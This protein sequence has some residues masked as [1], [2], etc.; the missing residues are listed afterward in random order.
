MARRFVK[1][2]N[3]VPLWVP[4]EKRQLAF[5]VAQTI[6]EALGMEAVITNI[7][8]PESGEEGAGLYLSSGAKEV[9]PAAMEHARELWRHFLR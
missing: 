9:P 5:R 1:D 4:R 8:H 6:T 3:G 7:R 2:E